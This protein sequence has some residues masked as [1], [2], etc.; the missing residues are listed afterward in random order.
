MGGDQR[1]CNDDG[2]LDIGRRL[3]HVLRQMELH[4]DRLLHG[5]PGKKK[6]MLYGEGGREGGDNRKRP[7]SGKEV[8]VQKCG[9]HFEVRV[10]VADGLIIP[11]L[12]KLHGMQI[13]RTNRTYPAV[14]KL[15]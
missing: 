6:E 2:F 1:G 12:R 10:G 9:R 13:T 7:K 11:V 3:V 8:V 4:R 14:S 5:E 15:V